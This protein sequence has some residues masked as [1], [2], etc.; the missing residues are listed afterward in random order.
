MLSKSLTKSRIAENL[1]VVQLTEED[2]G[3][4]AEATKGKRQRYCDFGD[5]GEC[6]SA[7]KTW[8]TD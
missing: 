5:I 6:P 8:L 7:Q 3:Q 2:I 4:I 1:R